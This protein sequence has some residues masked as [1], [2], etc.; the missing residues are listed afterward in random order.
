MRIEE[1]DRDAWAVGEINILLDRW[2]KGTVTDRDFAHG[3]RD[4]LHSEEHDQFNS[5]AMFVDEM[6]DNDVLYGESPD[7]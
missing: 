5:Y 3:V 7:Y 2:Q 6:P 1:Q 4:L